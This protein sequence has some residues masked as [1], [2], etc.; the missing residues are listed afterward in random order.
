MLAPALLDVSIVLLKLLFL[1][2]SK[3]TS[4]MQSEAAIVR[5]K[6]DEHH[7]RKIGYVVYR[8]AYGDDKRWSQF[9]YRLNAYVEYALRNTI[10]GHTLRD[11]FAFDIREDEQQ[12]NGASKT[13]VRR[14]NIPGCCNIANSTDSYRRLFNDWVN[15]V[16]GHRGLAKYSNC[17]YV[18]EEVIDA[19]LGGEDP[20]SPTIQERLNPR[21]FVKIFDGLYVEE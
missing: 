20:V 15:L 4:V 7:D 5:D 13:H 9:V 2:T 21:A 11:H 17:I 12:L 18:D 10:D 6:V 1:S 16:N 3:N 19:V 8:C 14:Q